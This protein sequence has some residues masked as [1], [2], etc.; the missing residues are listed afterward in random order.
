MKTKKP[1]K[2][3]LPQLIDAEA[4]I[5]KC[6]EYAIR[7]INELKLSEFSDLLNRV[8]LI[9][10]ILVDKFNELYPDRDAVKP[11]SSEYS[12]EI[13]EIFNQY[14]PTFRSKKRTEPEVWHRQ[15]YCYFMRKYTNHSLKRIGMPFGS[16]HTTILHSVRTVKKE[17]DCENPAFVEIVTFV[18]NKLIQIKKPT[19]NE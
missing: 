10:D 16:D 17:L 4:H 1:R 9:K 8:Y 12:D 7:G 2:K 18:E 5:V 11:H 14:F 6:N 19:P 13:K 3:S 15:C